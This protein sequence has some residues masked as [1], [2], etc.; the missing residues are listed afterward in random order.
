MKNLT[1][2]KILLVSLGILLSPIFANALDYPHNDANYYGCSS[3]HDFFSSNPYLVSDWT[4]GYTMADADD[5]PLNH[6]CR[7]C[8]YA[9]G[10]T[11]KHNVHSYIGVGYASAGESQYGPWQVE[12]STC[13]NPHEHDQFMQNRDSG[14]TYWQVKLLVD[15]VSVSDTTSTLK[16]QGN[17]GWTV[18]EHK[19]LKVVPNVDSRYPAVYKITGN[20]SDTLTIKGQMNISDV[21]NGDSFAIIYSKLV[22]KYIRLDRI[23]NPM[24]PRS[25]W[26]TVKLFNASGTNSLADGDNTYDGVCEVCHQE[27]THFRNDGSG[28]DQKHTNMGLALG[29]RC[30]NCHKAAKG[31]RGACDICHGEPPVDAGTLVYNP[32]PTGSTTAGAHDKHVNI[33]SYGCANCHYNSVGRGPTHNFAYP[34]DITIG[35]Y[36]FGGD[37]R[38]GIYDGQASATYDTSEASTTVT[39]T[40]TKTCNNLYC[41]SNAAPF[42]KANAYKT[43][44]WDGS[45]SCTSCHDA[46]GSSTGLSARHGKHTDGATYA[47]VCEKC[48]SQTATGSSAI[49]NEPYH[50]NNAKD[51]VFSASGTY[52]SAPKSCTSTYCHSDAKGGPP[53]TAVKWT[54][55]ETVGDA[56][57][58]ECHSG[59]TSDDIEVNCINPNT[60][61][62]SAGTCTAPDQVTC[63]SANGVWDADEGCYTTLT[64]RT[65]GHKALVTNK[66]IRKYPCNFC[67]DDTVDA[68]SNVDN[69]SKHV[70]ESKD[71]AIEP[72][73]HLYAASAPPSFDSDTK[74]CYNLYC[75]SDGTYEDPVV[76]AFPW[77]DPPKGCNACHG[78]S[79]VCADCHSDER[80]LGWGSTEEWKSAMPMYAGGDP[81]EPRANSHPRHLQTDFT[82]N[83]CHDKTLSGG[84]CQDCHADGIPAGTMREFGHVDPVFHVNKSK[85][86]YFP[87]DLG[88]YD[89][90]EGFKKC[91]STECHTGTDPQWGD[92]INST[93][94]CLTCHGSASGD[95]DDFGSWND[96]RAEIDTN[97]WVDAGH[98][99]SGTA[100]PDPD[101]PDGDD[102]DSGNPPA[103]FPGNPCWYCHDNSI[104]HKDDDNP[105][106]LK[107]HDQFSKRFDKECTYCHLEGKDSE[108]LDCHD[109]AAPT[110]APQLSVIYASAGDTRADG[111]VAPARLDHS[112]YTVP[113]NSCITNDCHG[114][115]SQKFCSDRTINS[116][117]C[118]V[119][120]DCPDFASGE[121]CDP[122]TGSYPVDTWVHNVDADLWTKDLKDDIQNQYLM[123]GVC[124][125]CHDDDSNNKCT[126]C[127]TAPPEDPDKYALG[128]DPGS[129][130]VAGTTKATS[131]HFGYKH[132][133]AYESSAKTQLDTGTVTVT[134]SSTN[135]FA[136]GSQSWAD[137]EWTG[138]YVMMDS[139]L[140]FS[141][142]R[143]IAS[144]TGNALTLVGDFS[145]QPQIGDSYYINDLVWK[146]GKFCW[147]CHDPHGDKDS[148]DNN[149]LYMIQNEVATQT[150]GVFG[151]PVSRKPVSFTDKTTGL[152]YIN[153]AGPVWDGICNV[154]HTDSGMHYRSDYGDGHNSGRVCTTCHEHRFSDS[155]ASGRDCG[156]CH[157]DKPIPRHSGF[158]LP[159]DCTK[160]HAGIIGKRVDVI[161]QLSLTNSHHIQG[162]E[163]TN[164]HCYACHWEATEDGLINVDHHSG[165]N[166]KTHNGTPNAQAD[167]VIWG[168]GTRPTTH[169][170][171]V[172]ATSFLATNI[173][174]V[175]ERTDVGN[176]TL[177]CLGCHSKQNNE[178][179]PFNLVEPL[180]GDCKTPNQY[181]W[182]GTS[183]G[184]RYSQTE[185]TTWGKYETATAAAPRNL[186][187]AFSAHGNAV[188]NEGGWDDAEG[189]DGDMSSIN[190][191][192][193]GQNVQ[194]FDC[195]SSH[196]SRTTGITSSYK[197]FN[198]TNNGANLKETQAG[199]GGYQRSYKARSNQ[200]TDPVNPYNEGAAQCFDC[201]ETKDARSEIYAN[202]YSP[203]GYN[204][205]FGADEGMPV[206]GYKDTSYFGQGVKSST[207][208]F[209]TYRMS[210]AT[211]LGGH[212]NASSP[213]YTS[214][215]ATH[216]STLTV[217]DTSMSWTVD[218][219]A[220]HFV[221]METGANAGEQR[222]VES[223]TS[224]T[225]SVEAGY[226]FASAVGAGDTY[227]VIMSGLTKDEGI[228]TGGSATTLVDA[229][230]NWTAASADSGTSGSGSS[231][232]TIKD[233][234]KSWA[235]NEWVD[236][237]VLV[238]TGSNAGEMRKIE[239][240]TATAFSIDSSHPFDNA[241]GPGETYKILINRQWVNYYLHMETG[242]NAGS[243]RR[244]T[245]NT[246]TQLTVNEFAYPVASGD[247]YRIVPYAKKIG[248]LCTPCHDP[249]GVSPTLGDNQRYAVP[250]LKGTWL[251]S[252]YKEDHPPADPTGGC[253]T[254]RYGEEFKVS[255]GRTRC[256]PSSALNTS[257]KY[258]IDRNTF[259]GNGQNRIS[260]DAD[261]FAGLCL[262]CHPKDNLTD[263][264]DNAEFRSL[265]RIH[266]AV[267]GWGDN[268]E[269]SFPCSKCHQAHVSGLP[270]LMQTNCLD[271]EHRGERESGGRASSSKEWGGEGHS[272][273]RGYP[274]G[275]IMGN[276]S[277]YRSQN[278]CHTQAIPNPEST[279]PDR[280]RWNNVTPWQEEP[281]E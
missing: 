77:D 239:S 171:G 54:D 102:Y 65:D 251:T 103:N 20:D 265:T 37:Y 162:V 106:R 130:L 49:K 218:E 145:T 41:H 243:I 168:S 271:Y 13:H 164:R 175:N 133:I 217:G 225:L 263:S 59:R 23:A 126:Q 89:K 268:N 197:T 31:F 223:N 261:K 17:P 226:P 222:K 104:L 266:T 151:I 254:A 43:P 259:G 134:A 206:M 159:K 152:D 85:D 105:F 279:Y 131:T 3:C 199:K 110:L 70:N 181:A 100:G 84:A 250:M 195:H 62:A 135:G 149:N 108:C 245:E 88:S 229:N 231:A 262:G 264:D 47:F 25:G 212:L 249:H 270:R 22:R 42:D 173:G 148:N 93:V 176:V 153:T 178:T 36:L 177:M 237:F 247:A 123:I 32:G 44:V 190:T 169:Q 147:D 40:G 158:G 194:C 280:N 51:I 73:W 72:T 213:V 165:Y 80:A 76:K 112:G 101:I 56:P 221:L 276:S 154:C 189:Q 166:F 24:S 81:G 179:E 15:T 58:Y 155:H 211:I 184:E 132:F 200:D 183:I 66:W 215:T 122:A 255:W 12:C 208:R 4:G 204:E 205:T 253:S 224:N 26:K 174:T 216:G 71:I 241:V 201:H 34:V 127:H 278:M 5:T 107:M 141:E 120:E 128:Y 57:C 258:Q 187:K 29:T 186:T 232:V 52:S 18:D 163:V 161:T 115:D 55:S 156:E 185:T 136:D 238:E 61:D 252:P 99:R 114:D 38:G 30:T 119:D 180:Q 83:Q 121:T 192:G 9:G 235:V 46:G 90:R 275:N 182:D 1:L 33:K 193:G 74:V 111:A 246:T 198:G 27:T 209:A 35:F 202:N 281:D 129:G 7:S 196:G 14:D 45:V 78:H 118:S 86:V 87:G 146:G 210:R 79:G 230:K 109:T 157:E 138:K 94:I 269:H 188:N 50:V 60:W 170:P 117:Y 273:Y 142:N 256:G 75:H 39:N 64:M 220:D 124:L 67:H 68:S 137:D 248:G 2:I 207:S 234:S 92:S 91:S 244:I 95:V 69:Y 272:Q 11:D 82:C 219:W 203:W 257:I 98:G 172:T 8:H 227:K 21:S 63:E 97:E 144:N 160:C 10:P 28:S 167:L 228:S 240:N 233:N 242:N 53:N 260:E 236:Y 143:K 191:R 16:A 274:I 140:N 96:V 48:H 150:D 214:G 125:K 267:K 113:A 139:G 277:S 6:L 116:R 19:D